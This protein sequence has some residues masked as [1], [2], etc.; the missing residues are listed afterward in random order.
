LVRLKIVSH[1]TKW[2]SKTPG[3]S[4]QQEEAGPFKH[5]LQYSSRQRGTHV[6]DA[7]LSA[8]MQYRTLMKLVD[9]HKVLVVLSHGSRPNV[10]KINDIWFAYVFLFSTL[11]S[12]PNIFTARS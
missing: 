1:T 2:T 12:G 3:Y 5:E 10:H 7:I 6:D 11:N 8:L 4:K 9:A